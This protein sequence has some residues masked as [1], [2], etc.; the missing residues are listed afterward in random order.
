MKK[1]AEK[2]IIHTN[3]VL[4]RNRAILKKLSPLGKTIVKKE[5]LDALDY[6]FSLF[7]SIFVTSKNAVY[8]LVYDYGLTPLRTKDGIKKVLVVTKGAYTDQFDPWRF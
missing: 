5:V 3:T 1:S 6:N 7:T 4:R 2:N 8:Y